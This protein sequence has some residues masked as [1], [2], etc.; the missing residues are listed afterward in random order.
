M[1]TT[2]ILRKLSVQIKSKKLAEQTG[3]ECMRRLHKA[4]LD[5]SY[6]E[7]SR[8]SRMVDHLAYTFALYTVHTLA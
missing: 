2:R 8:C 3:K 6:G 1:F 7:D 4:G 5:Y